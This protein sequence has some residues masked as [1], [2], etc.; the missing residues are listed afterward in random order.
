MHIV[1]ALGTALGLVILLV[2]LAASGMVVAAAA[3]GMNV[4]AP[5]GQLWFQLDAASLNAAQAM[6]E[7]GI[8]PPLWSGFVRPALMLPGFVLAGI[9]VLGGLLLLVRARRRDGRSRIFTRR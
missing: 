4:M 5:M 8:W 2:G 9:A 6:I 3:S 7:R 1:R